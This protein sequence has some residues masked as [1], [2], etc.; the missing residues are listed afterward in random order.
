MLMLPLISLPHTALSLSALCLGTGPFGTGL[1]QTET[2]RLYAAFREAGGNC[3]DTAHCYCFWL[4]SGNGASERALGECIRRHGDSGHVRV[5]T[6][7][8]HPAQLPDYPRA[9]YFLSPEVIASD[10]EDSLERLGG[11]RIDLYFLHRD[12]S[13]VPVGEIMDALAAHVAVGELGAIGAS[14][15]T[16]G[17][18]EE[19][20]AWAAAHGGPGFVASQPE[21]NLAR[22]NRPL[23]TGDPAMRYLTSEDI[24]W[25]T[26]H[27]FPVICYAST[28]NGYFAS[29][30]QRAGAAYE[31]PTSRARLERV[32]ELAR[33]L[34][35]TP[36]QIA[37]AWL[38]QQLFPTI[39]I[40]G[41]SSVEHL[42][43][44]L[45]AVGGLLVEEQLH[46]LSGTE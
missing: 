25:H 30:G 40:L 12:D 4:P 7:G 44:A 46:W 6:K 45:G 28:A 8:G 19:A 3:F 20:N 24:A 31:N 35:A 36:N 1:G 42:Q 27:D 37:L 9:D 23:E 17:R 13:R 39:P 41:T 15:W 11:E 5:I 32:E 34:D 14:N 33:Q 10:I 22:N 18:I 2:D 38:I 29:G 43:D 21:F 26:A 16:T